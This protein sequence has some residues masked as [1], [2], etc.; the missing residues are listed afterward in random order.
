MRSLEITLSQCGQTVFRHLFCLVMNKLESYLFPKPKKFQQAKGVLEFGKSFCLD[1]S[2]GRFSA[3]QRAVMREILF[4]SGC[5]EERDNGFVIYPVMVVDSI[6]DAVPEEARREFYHLELQD[7]GIWIFAE[8]PEGMLMGCRTLATILRASF[9]GCPIHPIVVEDWPSM[10]V[11]GVFV[12][13]KWGPDRMVFRDWCKTIDLMASMKLNTMGIGLYGCWGSCRFEGD[14][15]PTEFLMTPVPDHPEMQS[16][17]HLK[18]FSPMKMSWRKADYLPTLFSNPGML[19]K[20]VSYA[21]KRG[22]T[23]IPFVNSFG[24]NSLFPRLYSAVSAKDAEGQP[25]GVGYCIT[26]AETRKFV[27]AFY[28]SIIKKYYPK[29]AKYF[30]IQLDEVWPERPWPKDAC[31]VG[32]PW[33]QCEECRRHTR[34]ENF[35]DYLLWLVKTLTDLGVEK[36]V[37]WNDQLAIDMK[38]LNAD[39]VKRLEKAGLKDRLIFHWWFYSNDR[40]YEGSH[41]KASTELG[42]TSWVAPMT[43]YFNWKTYDCRYKN[44][45]L[46]TRMGFEEGASGAVSYAVHDTSHLDHEALLAACAW[47]APQDAEALRLRWAVSRFGTDAKRILA[48]QNK[49]REAASNPDY[50]VCPGYNYTY[51]APN[52]PWPRQYPE[53]ALQLLDTREGDGRGS[54]LAA[55][56]LA[57]EAEKILCMVMKRDDLQEQDYACLRSL[58]AEAAR[59]RGFA[60]AFA[61]LLTMRTDG[62]MRKPTAQEGKAAAKQLKSLLEQL[63]VIEL[64]KPEWVMPVC[65]HAFTPVCQYLEKLARG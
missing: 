8:A 62:K 6:P 27:A 65:M 17:H 34:E 10:P 31:K 53:E 25:T 4:S 24:H 41:A 55:S 45:E 19:G 1:F 30:H 60:E 48:A 11:R 2:L 9:D 3:S 22:V 47:E 28:A 58:R 29:G 12:E 15:Y 7:A 56:A 39:F 63:A 64:N 57:K 46:M 5:A 54:L 52:K 51:C 43:C 61:W 14:E 23:V 33:C 26:S 18:W 49:L 50:S 35:L 21:E 40:I 38:L 44:I 42:L 13:N 37:M 16:R 36:V 32:E 59:I 20:I